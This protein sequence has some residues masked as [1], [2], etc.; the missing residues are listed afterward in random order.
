MA[1]FTKDFISFFQELK[2][3]NHKEWFD[4]NRK[5]YVQSVKEPFQAFVAHMIDRVS[6]DDPQ[7]MITPKEAIFRINR[8]IR[9]SKDKTPYKTNVSAII[10]RGGKK[11]KTYPGMYFEL[12][13]DEVRFYGGVYMLDK[14]QLHQVRSAI[15]SDLSGF[16]AALNDAA[17][18][19]TFKTLHG[20][21]NKRLPKEFQEVAKK[22]PLIAN[23]SFYYYNILP[24]KL[25]TSDKLP[26]ELMACYDQSKP[27]RE[28]L[29][30][31]IK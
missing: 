28:W 21:Q 2:E 27:M 29:G 4:A 24:A 11:D 8:D 16:E 5:R 9:F 26:D 17:F 3:N 7:I 22:Q 1:Y 31:A 25:I 15:A 6:E 18:K 19:K 14:D 12:K 30:N 10:S 20:E 13:P 23:K